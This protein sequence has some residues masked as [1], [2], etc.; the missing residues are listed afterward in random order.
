MKVK[1]RRVKRKPAPIAAEQT[2][3]IDKSFAPIINIDIESM[4]R[5]AA[6][7]IEG[8]TVERQ[9][10]S[11]LHV[12]TSTE[13]IPDYRFVEIADRL[14]HEAHRPIVRNAKIKLYPNLTLKEYA[15]IFGI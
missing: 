3:Q 12:K 11:A 14:H 1:V 2:K 6:K 15:E 8:R 9:R 5:N 10:L 13:S 4:M 7:N